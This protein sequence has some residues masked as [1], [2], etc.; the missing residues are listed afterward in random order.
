MLVNK[1]V[2]CG[3]IYNAVRVKEWIRETKS[4]VFISD[5]AFGREEAMLDQIS[6]GSLL[7]LADLP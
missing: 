1:I 6:K 4:F 7:I 2:I 3:S 5:L